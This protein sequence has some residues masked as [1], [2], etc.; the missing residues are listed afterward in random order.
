MALLEKR[1]GPLPQVLFERIQ[2]ISD[3]T[4]LN[5]ARQQVLD[6][7]SPNELHL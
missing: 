6:I 5:A 3:I 4:R 1:F 2:A 7:S